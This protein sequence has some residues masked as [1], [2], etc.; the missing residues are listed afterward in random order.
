MSLPPDIMMIKSWMAVDCHII[1]LAV[2]RL[3]LLVSLAG[4]T[5]HSSAPGLATTGWSHVSQP[6][7]VQPQWTEEHQVF[8]P[9]AAFQRHYFTDSATE[10]APL[11]LAA[12]SC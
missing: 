7:L 2:W 8:H 5:G 6:C 9:L 1:Y 4:S 12:G 10:A 11:A 3:L